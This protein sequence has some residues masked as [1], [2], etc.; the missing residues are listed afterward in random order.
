MKYDSEAL[1]I[2][3]AEYA[4]IYDLFQKCKDPQAKLVYGSISL[5]IGMLIMEMQ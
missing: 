5:H 1:K 3:K 4:R 2:A